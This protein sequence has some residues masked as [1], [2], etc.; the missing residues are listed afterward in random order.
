[1]LSIRILWEKAAHHRCF[2]KEKRE[3]AKSD[4][5]KVLFPDIGK[6]TNL[7]S[8]V[9]FHLA[10][11]F[12]FF[13]LFWMLSMLVTVNKAKFS[14]QKTVIAFSK[15]PL[16]KTEFKSWK[17][18]YARL[19]PPLL[20]SL[21]YMAC[22]VFKHEISDWNKYFSYSLFPL[23]PNRATLAYFNKCRKLDKQLSSLR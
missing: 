17:T 5:S 12:L 14:L 9:A 13:V 3:S 4:V 10:S 1:M 21:K 7:E 2:Q 8:S 23:C 18:I 20:F 6:I 15:F 16:Y 22:H 19:L 11:K